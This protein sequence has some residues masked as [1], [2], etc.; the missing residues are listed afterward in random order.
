MISSITMKFA[1]SPSFSVSSSNLSYFWLFSRFS[2]FFHF[3]GIY[4]F[5]LSFFFFSFYQLNKNLKI[6]R[7]ESS[8]W[9]FSDHLTQG[10]LVVDIEYPHFV[11]YDAVTSIVV[12]EIDE[13]TKGN[14]KIYSPVK[15]GPVRDTTYYV[16]TNC[17][18]DIR[19]GTVVYTTYACSF[20]LVI[21]ANI[22]TTA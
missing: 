15:A 13:Q 4:W 22:A 11:P 10:T 7:G 2:S 19:L 21:R 6:K 14:L 5:Y 20:T 18:A 9:I 17:S 12:D 16:W 3:R 1:Y 8:I